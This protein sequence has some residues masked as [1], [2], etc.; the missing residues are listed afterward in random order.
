LYFNFWLRVACM[1]E[2]SALALPLISAFCICAPLCKH[3]SNHTWML[4]VKQWHTL[5]QLTIST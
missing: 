5:T 3:S 4:W 1:P 2:A